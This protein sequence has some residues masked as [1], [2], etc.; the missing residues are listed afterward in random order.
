MESSFLIL[1]SLS[2]SRHSPTPAS[3]S[4]PTSSSSYLRVSRQ[5]SLIEVP[6]SEAQLLDSTSWPSPSHLNDYCKNYLS[7]K[8][9]HLPRKACP[10]SRCANP[11]VQTAQCLL[12]LNQRTTP[13][14]NP[15][16]PPR[17]KG[18]GLR[19]CSPSSCCSWA[20][21]S[22]RTCQ[23]TLATRTTRTPVCTDEFM[24]AQASGR[25]TNGCVRT[26]FVF[27]LLP[28]LRLTSHVPRLR[29]S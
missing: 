18:R 3:G 4:A 28:T 6:M 7:P 13:R 24:P 19:L 9:L 27:N 12:H 2:T 21:L 15:P 20:T 23:S 11:R 1:Q 14:L 16:Q 26:P 8:L 17:L 10:S 29:R 22:T 25:S 5:I